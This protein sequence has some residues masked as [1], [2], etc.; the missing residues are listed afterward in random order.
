MR[1]FLACLLLSCLYAN[2]QKVSKLFVQDA[3]EADSYLGNWANR[4]ACCSYSIIRSN[5]VARDGKYSMR[6]ELN[7]DDA[8]V[9]GGK[10]AE[11]I[12][13][14]ERTPN[15]ER[16]YRFSIFLPIDY[17]IDS[18][19]E[20]V[21]QWHEVPDFDLGETWRSPPISLQINKDKWVAGV[22]W[23]SN[24][25]NTN[26]TLSGRKYAT[27]GVIE[28]GKWTDWIFHI[29]FSYKEDGILQIWKDSAQVL[30]Y[31]GPNYYNDRVGP[32]FKLGI[33]KWRWQDVKNKSVVTQ[34]ILYFDRVK[35]S[36]DST[37][38]EIMRSGN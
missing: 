31:S 2:G 30:D 25:V 34:R 9:H 33:Y 17:G 24:P 22:S 16:W 27:L 7:K 35:I 12:T 36:N 14:K 5:S 32:Y 20:I 28:R 19:E 13:L 23:A 10:R 11:L 38:L 18:V 6:F 29:R 1:I 4:E 15:V 8:L 3:F 21:A 26:N 37:T